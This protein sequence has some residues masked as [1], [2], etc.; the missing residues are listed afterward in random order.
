MLLLLYGFVTCIVLILLF[1]LL[2]TYSYTWLHS[3][4]ISSI[5]LI[6]VLFLVH[7]YVEPSFSAWQYERNMRMAYPLVDYAAKHDPVEYHNYMDEAQDHFLH[8]A[9]IDMGNEVYYESDFVNVL[10]V[11]Y[12]SRASNES[13]YAF[14]KKSVD[15]DRALIKVDPIYVLYHEFP[16]KFSDVNVDFSK[17]NRKQYLHEI[18]SSA[19]MVVNSAIEQPVAEPTKEDVEKAKAIFQDAVKTVTKTYNEKT[20]IEALQMPHD[21]ML[22]KEQAAQIVI[23]FFDAILARSKEEVGVF[24]RVTFKLDGEN[25]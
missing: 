9:S 14:L 17:L 12:G 20:V 5:A 6:A 7:Y 22:N 21:P 15:Y 10:L 25:D 8:A 16:E 13:L 11:K 3:F 24:L 1:P 19:A 4:I 23:A 18:F 2:R